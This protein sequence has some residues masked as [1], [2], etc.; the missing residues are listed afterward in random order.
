MLSLVT[1]AEQ[2]YR[3]QTWTRDHEIAVLASI[4]E[5]RAASIAPKVVQV[6]PRRKRSVWARP[7]GL[8]TEVE[9]ATTA[10]AVA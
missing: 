9:C 7:I 5:R 8:H 6:A 4:R 3:H 1:A 2:Q 10:C